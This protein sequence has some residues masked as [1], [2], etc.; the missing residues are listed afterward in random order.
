MRC[1]KGKPVVRRGRKA[2]GPPTQGGSR[3]TE[4]QWG[5]APLQRVEGEA[6]YETSLY[7]SG[8]RDGGDDGVKRSMKKRILVLVTVV[9]MMVVMVAMSVAPAFA[10]WTGADGQCRDDGELIDVR[11]TE[12]TPSEILQRDRNDDGFVCREVRLHVQFFN[13]HFYDNRSFFIPD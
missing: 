1:E 2:R 8:G 13:L 11:D 10:A 5:T 6:L 7:A 9:A 12:G 3:V 4:Q